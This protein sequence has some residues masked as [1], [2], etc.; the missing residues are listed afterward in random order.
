MPGRWAAAPTPPQIQGP[1]T[2][3]LLFPRLCLGLGD[4]SPV[5]FLA[6]WGVGWGG[7]GNKRPSPRQ[8]WS[9][10]APRPNSNF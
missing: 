2:S 6:S 8:V 3:L 7:E 10:R 1:V 5:P 9:P 4:T